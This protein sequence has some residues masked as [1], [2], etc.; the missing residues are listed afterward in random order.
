[1][2]LKEQLQKIGLTEAEALIYEVLL[3][4]SPSSTGR[5]IKETSLQSSTVYHCIGSLI[6]KGLIS[7]FVK[8]NIKYF[9]TESLD[10]L[11]RF[12][13]TKQK[14]FMEVEKNIDPL[15]NTLI[16]SNLSEESSI[17]IFEGWRGVTNAFFECIGVLTSKD[18]IYVFTLSSYAGA[19]KEQA[20]YL[21]NKL[22]DLRVKKKIEEKVIINYNEKNTLGKDHENT[23]RTQVKYLPDNLSH[24]AIVHI[25][26]D[27]ILIAISSAKPLALVVKNK[28]MAESFRNYFNLLWKLAKF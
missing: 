20:S 2:I 28:V 13:E 17:K 24:P 18:I 23:P 1:M 25:Y 6:Y 19:S 5:I 11:K 15:I 26:G 10:T 8:N 16:K 4:I 22:R 21:I 9:Q 12:I 14:E 3:K 27:T 7:F